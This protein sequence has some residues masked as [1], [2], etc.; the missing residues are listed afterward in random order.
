MSVNIPLLRKAVEWVEWQE[1]L[2]EKKRTWV[3][4]TWTSLVTKAGLPLRS[5]RA[6]ERVLSSGR[7]TCQTSMCVA[8]WVALETGWKPTLI[9][10]MV[11]KNGI[12]QHVQEIAAKE[13]GIASYWAERLFSGSNDAKS[14]RHYAELAA[15]ERL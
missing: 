3:Q 1:L 7:W 6:A 13:L 10:G 8:G 14:I 5:D 15:E 4:G 2:P 12:M 11:E 9:N